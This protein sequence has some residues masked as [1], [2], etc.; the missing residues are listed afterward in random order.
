[1]SQAVGLWRIDG[2]GVAG[3]WP[4]ISRGARARAQSPVDDQ[5][6]QTRRYLLPTLD[7]VENG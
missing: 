5:R 7:R 2:V 6:F 1:M 4:I 3:K